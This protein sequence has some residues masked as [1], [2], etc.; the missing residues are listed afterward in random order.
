MHVTPGQMYYHY[1]YQLGVWSCFK[2]RP[3]RS[4]YPTK[5]G[6]PSLALFVLAVPLLP[7]TV[8]GS[9]EVEVVN[10]E[11]SNTHA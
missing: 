11:Q 3:I 2:V 7:S 4:T 8:G 9:E 5:P 10:S 6:L 1:T